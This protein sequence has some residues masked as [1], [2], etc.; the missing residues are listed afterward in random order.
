[1]IELSQKKVKINLSGVPQTS[2]MPLYGRAKISK[3]HNSLFNDPGAVE[4]VERIDYDFSIVDQ[5][6]DYFWFTYAA[7][8][9]Q[10]D[11]KVRRYIREHPDASIVNLGAG[12]ETAFYRIDNG[13]VRWYDLDLPEIIDIRKQ[14]FPETD[15]MT[16]ISKS[17]LEPDWCD[18]INTGE[19]VFIVAG[20]LFHYFEE[21]D[22]HRFFSLLADNLPGSEI[23]FEAESRSSAEIDGNY[24]AYGPGWSDDEPWKRDALQEEA[25]RAFKSMWLIAPPVVREHLIGNLTT[26]TRPQGTEWED[27]EIWWSGIEAEEKGKAMS[28]IVAGSDITCRSPF[29]DA[30]EIAAWDKRI[31]VVDQFPLFRDIPRDPSLSMATRQFMDYTD[32]KGRMKIFHLRV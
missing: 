29:E 27:F 10:F 23:V 4:I 20:G 19:G 6:F 31:A 28:D 17:F 5:A 1:M 7:R 13:T 16:C 15:R 14:L 24:G 32:E 2:L 12:F 21:P 30:G 11:N 22:I 25:L 9:M 3:N 8:A 18:D 26:P